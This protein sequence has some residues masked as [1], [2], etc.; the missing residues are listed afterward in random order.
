MKG[1]EKDTI[2]S[3]STVIFD[4][5]G[6]IRYSEPRGVDVFHQLVAESG[7]PF[8]EEQR[9]SAERWLHYYWAQSPELAVDVQRFGDS[10]NGDFWRQHARRHLELLGVEKGDVED[11]SLKITDQ[12]RSEYVSENCVSDDVLPT[13]KQLKETDYKLAVVSNRHEKFSSLLK[14]LEILDYFDLTLAAGEIGAWKPDPRLLRHAV[15]MLGVEAGSS[16]YVG[17]N[18][19]ADV[20]GARAAGLVP[21]LLDPFDIYLDSDGDGYADV[22]VGQFD[23]DEGRAHIF[24]CHCTCDCDVWGDVTGDG[25]VNPV[26]VVFMVNRVYLD[27]DM[28]AQHDNCPRDAADVNRDDAV[29]PVD[30][31]YFVNRIYLDHDMFCVDPCGE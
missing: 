6:T 22:V 14:E 19:Y 3:I 12:M 8:S 15:E 20:L 17:D 18:Y 21:V 5:D 9:K 28:T 30:I 11:L 25:N 16:I 27:N 2:G 24:S 10:Q 23:A 31:V 7:V 29:N 13:L 1:N 26:D 4:L